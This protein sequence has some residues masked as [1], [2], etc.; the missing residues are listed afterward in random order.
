MHLQPEGLLSGALLG[1]RVTSNHLHPLSNF[2]S[3][4]GDLKAWFHAPSDLSQSC[5]LVVVLHGCTQTVQGYDNG[6][7]WSELAEAYGFAVLFPEQQRSNNPN[8]CFNWFS[9]ADTE[10]GTG[11]PLSIAQMIDTMIEHRGVDEQRVFITGLSA[12]GAMTSVM[13]ATYPEKFAGGAILAGLPHGAAAS[14]PEAFQQMR[15]HSPSKRTSGSFI[16]EASG[17]VGDWP[18]ISIWHGTPDSVFDQ[19][20]A[21]AIL[22]QWL[23]VQNLPEKPDEVGLVDGQ[24]RRAWHNS[25]GKLLLEEYRV[26]GMG[27]GVPLATRGECGSGEAG[28]FMLEAGI[29]STVH[30]ARTWGLLEGEPRTPRTATRE[31]AEPHSALPHQSSTPVGQV[32][33]NAL[34]AAGL[35]K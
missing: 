6:S 26:E 29:S 10:R 2:G 30:S 14:V 5:P 7:G 17:H 15:A 9:P 23:E 3:N 33:E 16:R 20:N 31:D 18:M 13:L 22:R 21:D 4:P 32:I 24:P 11:E 1:G 8:L 28:A 34:R 27:H 25:R 19:S 35:M 12:G